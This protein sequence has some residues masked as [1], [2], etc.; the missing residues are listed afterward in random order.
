M[1]HVFKISLV[2]IILCF[3]IFLV[4]KKVS[5]KQNYKKEEIK[6]KGCGCGGLF[7]TIILFLILAIVVALKQYGE[8]KLKYYDEYDYTIVHSEEELIK[9]QVACSLINQ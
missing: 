9:H 1:E 5:P 3:I 2:I 6:K 8:T 7:A 4:A